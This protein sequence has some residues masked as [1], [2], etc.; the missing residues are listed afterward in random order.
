MILC[1]WGST[2]EEFWEKLATVQIIVLPQ[3][4][5]LQCETDRTPDKLKSIL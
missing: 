3:D 4:K 2:W 5:C 1:V